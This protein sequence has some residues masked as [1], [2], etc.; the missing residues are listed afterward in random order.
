MYLLEKWKETETSS[1][2]DMEGFVQWF[3][4]NKVDVICNSMLRPIREES[5]LGNPP[6]I[7]TTNSSVNVNAVLKH[8]VNYKKND[9]ASVCE[10]SQGIDGRTTEKS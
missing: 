6:S 3:E 7:F 5:G 9:L 4:R 1:C 10:Q 2:A 8:K